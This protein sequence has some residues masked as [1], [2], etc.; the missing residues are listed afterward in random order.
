MIMIVLQNRATSYLYGRVST[1]MI[2][3]NNWGISSFLLL[4]LVLWDK[5]ADLSGISS[6][7]VLNRTVYDQ[8]T[9]NVYYFAFDLVF[10]K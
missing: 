2:C 8:F 1:S 4:Y 10:N 9:Q 5:C 7:P 3:N 6:A